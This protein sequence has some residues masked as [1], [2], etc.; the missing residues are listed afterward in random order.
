MTEAD[1]WEGEG[2]A[3]M[4]P[5][6]ISSKPSIHRVTDAIK[7]GSILIEERIPLPNSMLLRLEPYSSGW[8]AVSDG[9]TAF[10]KEVE[11]AGWTFFFMAGEIKVTVFDFNRQK[12]VRT[13][14]KRLIANVKA[15]HCNC[16]QITRVVRKSFLGVPYLSIYAHPR[17][18][19]KGVAFS[20]QG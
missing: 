1:T 13:A 6:G 12:A 16:I 20:I 14:W 15:Q 18:L 8:S 5:P 3:T 10:E 9:G 2:G 11:Q 4:T 19:Q 7:A 17:H